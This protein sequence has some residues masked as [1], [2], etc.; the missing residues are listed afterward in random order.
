MMRPKYLLIGTAAVIVI[1]IAVVA[2]WLLSPLV[3]DRTVDEDLPFARN[4]VVPAGMTFEEVEQIM[5]GMAKVNQEVDEAMSADMMSPPDAATSRGATL[6]LPN[7]LRQPLEKENFRTPTNSIREAA[8]LSFTAFPTAPICFGWK[9][10]RLPM[11]RICMSFSRLVQIQRAAARSILPV[12]LPG[13]PQGQYWKPEL[14]IP[15]PI[16]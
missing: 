7:P 16:M 12:M 14:Y 2:W 5:A 1:P 11:A 15:F 13:F 3:V 6:T 4:A 10:L 8:R 9:T